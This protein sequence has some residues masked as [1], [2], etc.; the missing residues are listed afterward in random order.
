MWLY[1]KVII[2][3]ISNISV[4]VIV[5]VIIKVIEHH[6][7]IIITSNLSIKRML[8]PQHHIT[9]HI[10]INVVIG[11]AIPHSVNLLLMLM[12]F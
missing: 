3:L 2:V 10:T 4:N 8:A 6:A 11:K 5:I 12:L 7:T 1:S 9:T